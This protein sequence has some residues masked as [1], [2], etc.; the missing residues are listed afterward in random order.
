MFSIICPIDDN[1]LEHFLETKRVYDT[2]PE[3]KEFIMPTRTYHSVNLFLKDNGLMKDVNLIPYDIEIGFNP[4][5]ALNIGV[6]NSN[7]DNLIL[8]GPEVKPT[9]QVL[10]QLS[11]C[12]DKNIVCQTWDQDIDGNLTSLVHKGYRQNTP[13][14]YFLAMFQKK[15][16]EA[17][18][19]WDE[20]FMSGYA[21]EDDDFAARWVRA[22]LPFEIRDD[23]QATHLYHPRH[24][25]IEGGLVS[26][27]LL[28]YANTDNGVV[29][30]ANGLIK[31]SKS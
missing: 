17:I 1:R 25:T 23:I 8:T 10:E 9:T 30:P 15:D 12:L 28:Y 5:K 29:R 14:A 26:N 31:E 21:Y 13:Q 3:V 11:E 20:N 22:G 24:E 6:L 7:Y 2:F 27:Q 19:G 16:V 4:S 18:N